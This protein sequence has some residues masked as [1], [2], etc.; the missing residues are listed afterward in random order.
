MK[1]GYQLPVAQLTNRQSVTDQSSR[2]NKSISA[3]LIGILFFPLN[4]QFRKIHIQQV[5]LIHTEA[6]DPA[7]SIK[8]KG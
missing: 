2:F 3:Y 7:F 4:I 1:Y 6:G 5:R 8:I